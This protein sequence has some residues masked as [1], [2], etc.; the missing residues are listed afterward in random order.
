VLLE[1]NT[2]ELDVLEMDETDVEVS[3]EKGY[4][5]NCVC[6][7]WA[8]GKELLMR[9]DVKNSRKNEHG[10]YEREKKM[11]EAIGEYIRNATESR[12]D[13]KLKS[14]DEDG[15]DTEAVTIAKQLSSFG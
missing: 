15:S 1:E 5:V 6:D 7:I 2:V 11:M 8:K 13:T 10:R 12:Q 9:D 14:E 4:N 3:T